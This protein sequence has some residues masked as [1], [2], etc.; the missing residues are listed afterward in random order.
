MTV[1]FKALRSEETSVARGKQG[2]TKDTNQEAGGDHTI[3]VHL[4]LERWLLCVLR[5]V[6]APVES[7]EEGG[8]TQQW[9]A[10]RGWWSWNEMIGPFFLPPSHTHSGNHTKH[11]ETQGK[12]GRVQ[13]ERLIQPRP[14]KVQSS[15]AV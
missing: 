8:R 1:S 11:N 2:W 10:L 13:E 6:R 12:L 5:E 7:V 3:Q 9:S 4:A 14:R 15:G